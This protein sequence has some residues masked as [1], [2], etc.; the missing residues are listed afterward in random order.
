MNSSKLISREEKG[1]NIGLFMYSEANLLVH[2]LSH[3]HVLL[4]DTF[5]SGNSII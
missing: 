4:K 1:Q 3:A 2:F 5:W